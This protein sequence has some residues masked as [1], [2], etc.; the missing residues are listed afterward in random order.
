MS[1]NVPLSATFCSN[2]SPDPRPLVSALPGGLQVCSPARVAPLC[3]PRLTTCTI[4]ALTA[5]RVNGAL[6]V[7][8]SRG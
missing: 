8:D 4:F 3:S 7:A 5:K 2:R 6:L 1:Q